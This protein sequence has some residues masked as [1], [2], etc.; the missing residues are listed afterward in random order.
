MGGPKKGTVFPDRWITGPD[1]IRHKQYRVWLQQRNQANFREEGWTLEFDDWLEIWGELWFQ[2]GRNKDDYCMTRDD[3]EKPW[4]KENAIVVTRKEH[5]FRQRQ[6][7]IA[8]GKT[9]GYKKRML[10]H[11]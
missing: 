2:R 3:C 9:R 10:Q 11:G 4:S 8:Q 5:M 7:Q 1:P 6:Q